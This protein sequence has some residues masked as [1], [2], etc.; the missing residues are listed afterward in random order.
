MQMI[1]KLLAAI[2]LALFI[3]GML[4]SCVMSTRV[5]FNSEPAGAKVFLDGEYI[6]ETPVTAK[7]SNGVWNNEEV[8]IKKDGYRTVR[9]SLYRDVKGVNMVC[10]LLLWWPS[11][12]WCYGPKPNQTYFLDVDKS[13]PAAK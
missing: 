13:E 5:S 10:G 7:L 11:L 4:S 8:V 2:S 6:G 9:T 12:L 3:C 1:K